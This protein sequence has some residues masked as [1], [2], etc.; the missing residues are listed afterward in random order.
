MEYI[1]TPR[2]IAIYINKDKK[3]RNQIKEETGCTAIING[4][5]YDLNTFKPSCHLKVDNKIYAT[6][7]YTYYGFAWNT[8]KI[9]CVSNY[10]NYANFICCV[11]MIKDG[12]MQQM[13]YDTNVGRAT[14][15]TAIGVMPN[16]DIWLYC[17]K[18]SLTPVQ[19]QQIAFNAGCKHALM[20]DGGASTQCTT[21]T[22]TILSTRK[23]HNYICVWDYDSIT[24]DEKCIAY[25][26]LADIKQNEP[27]VYD[28]VNYCINN[29]L[30][31]N[32]ID[33][34]DLD[35]YDLRQL[36]SLYKLSSQ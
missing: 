12:Q 20:L 32:K 11:C 13:Y 36:Y 7:Q 26:T 35:Y 25:N 5:L 22:E 2:K 31:K 19:L 8:D 18:N 17:T 10:A 9:E 3:T 34:L 33:K 4:G 24:D 29:K 21:P 14:Y 1:C 27:W 6:D 30:L 16:N 15:R 23:V 28:A